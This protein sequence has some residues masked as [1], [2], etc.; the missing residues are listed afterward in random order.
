MA[1][2]ATTVQRNREKLRLVAYFLVI[3]VLAWPMALMLGR[4][5]K[6]AY[7]PQGLA[8]ALNTYLS[9]SLE[10]LSVAGLG[11]FLGL[12]VL[13][14]LD[15][16]KRWQGILLWIGTVVSLIGLKSMG[17]FLPNVDIVGSAV[18][19]VGGLV[20]GV[21]VGGGRRLAR[22]QTSEPLEFR[23]AASSIF[24]LLAVLIAV[25]FV[26]AHVNYPDIIYVGKE[27]ARLRNLSGF[28]VSIIQQSLVIDLVVSSGFVVTLGKF[29]EYDAEQDFFVLGP[30]ASGKSLFLIGAYLEALE[31]HA[32]SDTNTPM[33]PSNDLL[34]MVEQLDMD[35]SDWIVEAT[36]AGQV[37]ELSFRYV[38]GTIFPKNIQ[39]TSLDYAGE[40][41]D[42]LPDAL[43]GLLENEED[44]TLLSLARNVM[45]ANTLILIVDVERFDNNEPLEV[46]PYVSILQ[47]TDDKDVLLVATK[48]DVLADQFREE[49]GIE[50]HRYFEDF[51]Q[52]V[53][54]Q[55]QRNE[56]VR[57]LIQQTS[58]SEIHPVYY[59]TKE[60]EI[61]D[62][63]VPMRDERNSVMTVGFGRLLDRLG[64]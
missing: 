21:F 1:N 35:T 14:T 18:W 33:N 51:K 52:Y 38:H 19:L 55:L 8:D 15:P 60:A 34:G 50:A 6:G 12:L 42:R 16:K 29:M 62:G 20:L 63:R 7:V 10:Q 13:L 54:D 37:K 43:T 32:D 17:L 26:E 57:T 5:W 49:Q 30:P 22:F 11:F 41:L 56:Q 46:A 40:Y 44:Q 39:V 27:S 25:G 4:A 48:A 24:Y 53:N 59:Q 36:E 9:L 61:G 45:D 58:G 64:R 2:I 3:G 31:E 28:S 23:R 47:A